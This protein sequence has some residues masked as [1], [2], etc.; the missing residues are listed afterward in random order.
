MSKLEEVQ[1]SLQRLN[2]AIGIMDPQNPPSIASA[3]KCVVTYAL[4][5]STLQ[6][7]LLSQLSTHMANTAELMQ[8]LA[9]QLDEIKQG[10][11][12]LNTERG[13][14]LNGEWWNN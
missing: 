11:A 4:A 1:S 13:D 14:P 12:K 2:E 3:L 6:H 9:I 8:Q 5:D 10:L 7:D